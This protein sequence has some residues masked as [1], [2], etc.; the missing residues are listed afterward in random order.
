MFWSY[1][2]LC[3]VVSAC[4]Q[5]VVRAFPVT[6]L[7]KEKKVTVQQSAHLDQYLQE[8]IQLRSCTFQVSWFISQFAE[9]CSVI[10]TF[11]IFYIVFCVVFLAAD[12]SCI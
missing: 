2:I 4:E 12:E 7:T 8:G 10:L 1:N 9:V 3:P 6:S 5:V 11:N